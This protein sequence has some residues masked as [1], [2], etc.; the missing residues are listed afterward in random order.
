MDFR[1]ISLITTAVGCIILAI[2]FSFFKNDTGIFTIINAVVAFISLGIPLT[3]KYQE[4]NKIKNIELMFPKF[5]RDITQNIKS[6][7]TLPQAIRSTRDKEYGML[8]PY[9]RAMS[10]KIDWGINFGTV[11]NKFADSTRSKMLKRTVQTIIEAHASGGTID[12]VLE[13]V[14]SSLQ[15]IE[16]IKKERSAAVYSQMVNGYMIFIIFLGV[17]FGISNFLIP[18]FQWEG[19]ENLMGLYDEIFRNLI[20]IQGLFAGL[21]LGKMA[22]GTIIAGVKH[23]MVMVIIGYTASLFLI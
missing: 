7:M 11:L 23:S 14:S 18:S 21:S 13:A 17:M 16:K 19:T 10:S 4:Y 3:I 1:S 2:N 9:V 12:T 8:T 22:E 20:I 6:G 5:L 15:E